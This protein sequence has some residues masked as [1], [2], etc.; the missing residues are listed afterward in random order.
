MTAHDIADCLASLAECRSLCLQTVVDCLKHGGLLASLPHIRAM[1]DCTELCGTTSALLLRESPL[2][3]HLCAMTSE[4]CQLCV[5]DLKAF[6]DNMTPMMRN[7]VAVCQKTQ[8]R[9][10]ALFRFTQS[11]AAAA[12]SQTQLQEYDP[13]HHGNAIPG[14]VPGATPSAPPTNLAPPAIP[15]KSVQSP[16]QAK[17]LSPEPA[18]ASIGSPKRDKR[19]S[20]AMATGMRTD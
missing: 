11:A 8:T 10:L 3:G 13:H 19:T 9:T 14:A 4:A 2:A 1:N 6:G 20:E 17:I 16:P 15:A 18:V 7:V 12:R 5:I